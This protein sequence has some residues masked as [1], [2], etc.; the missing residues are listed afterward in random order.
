MSEWPKI[1]IVTP[2]YNQ[3][4]FLE[5]TI[6][7]V[8][9]QEY[10]NLEYIVIDGGS[11]DGSVEIL[12]KYA[13]RLTYWVSEPDR[14]QA[15]AIN[16]GFAR[17]TGDILAWLNSD[18]RYLPG[19]LYAVAMQFRQQ[20][21]DFLYGGCLFR[22]EDRPQDCW[23]RMPHSLHLI[24]SDITVLDFIDQPSSFWS[25]RVWEQTG[26]L[27]ES[28]HY[29]FDWD[30]FIRVSRAFPLLCTEGVY[31]VYRHHAAHKTGTG[32]EPRLEEIVEI[33]RR[34]G[35][36]DWRAAYQDVYTRLIP[37]QHS[38]IE[39]YGWLPRIRGGWRLFSML[40]PRVSMPF[41]RRHGAHKIRVASTMLGF[42]PHLEKEQAG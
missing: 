6:L 39:K 15:H 17:A 26:P 38:F 12:Q 10:P 31:S 9:N 3:A 4:Q 32:G 42:D 24:S 41:V 1:S 37:N 33:V 8:L 25:R 23:V 5:E 28:M 36:D 34:H 13:D 11:K 16:K 27:D 14:G 30:F 21:T 20:Q 7:S 18:D 40:Q 19:A 29:T 22:F 2:S 35:T